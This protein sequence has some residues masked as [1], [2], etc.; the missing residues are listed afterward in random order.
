LMRRGK[1]LALAAAKTGMDEKTVRRYVRLGR[2]PSELRA[3]HRWRT[4]EDPFADHWDEV[5]SMLEI[6]QAK[7]LFEWLQRLY[8]GQFSDG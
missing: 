4:R 7:A 1:T 2:L 5:R 6:N 3:D 8:P